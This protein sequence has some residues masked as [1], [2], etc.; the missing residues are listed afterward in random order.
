M[1]LRLEHFAVFASQPHQLLMTA[2]FRDFS[3]FYKDNA[4]AKARGGKPVRD[5]NSGFV[6]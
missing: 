6:F 2:A 3:V 5:V 4:A 1:T